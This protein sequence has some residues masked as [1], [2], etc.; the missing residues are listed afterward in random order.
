MNKTSKVLLS[1][2]IPLLFCSIAFA[3]NPAPF[4]DITKPVNNFTTSQNTLSVT[5]VFGPYRCKH[6]HEMLD[7]IEL[8]ILMIDSKKVAT[9]DLPKKDKDGRKDFTVNISSYTAGS[10]ILKAFAFKD[11]KGKHQ[12]AQSDPV[13]FIIQRG[14]TPPVPPVTTAASG[15]IVG[16]VLDSDMQVP[17]ISAS[18]TLR[19]VTGTV[20]TDNQGKYQFPSPAAGKYVIEFRKQGYTLSQRPVTVVSTR[21]TAVESVYM[22]QAD[23]VITNI[24]TAGGTYINSAGDV[25]I[26]I[27]SNA[28]SGSTASIN[29]QGTVFNHSSQLPGPL[30]TTSFFT[31]CLDLQPD[32]VHFIKPV[33]VK[34]ANTLNFLIGSQIPIGIYNTTTQRWDDTGWKGTVTADGKWIEFQTTHFSSPDCNNGPF[35]PVAQVTARSPHKIRDNTT[36]N[37]NQALKCSKVPGTSTVWMRTGELSQEH[38]LPSFK[39]LNRDF[40]LTLSYTSTTADPRAKIGFDLSADEDSYVLPKVTR[41]DLMLAGKMVR[42]YFQPAYGQTSYNYMFDC[43]DVNGKELSTGSYAYDLYATY[44]YD[45]LTYGNTDKFA[46]PVTSD[47]QV[48]L[49]E[50]CPL[51]T[52]SKSRFIVNNQQG[53]V[54]GAGWNLKGLQRIY[55]DPDGALLLT[56]GDS[57]A[58]VFEKQA[59]PNPENFAIATVFSR[60]FANVSDGDGAFAQ[61]I[62]DLSDPTHGFYEVEPTMVFADFNN[63]GN[64]DMAYTYPKNWVANY[65]IYVFFGNGD[66]TFKDPI[67][68]NIGMQTVKLYTADVN[69]DSF[70]DLIVQT[71]TTVEVLLGKGDGTFS[72]SVFSLASS[73]ASLPKLALLDDLNGDHKVDFVFRG[74]GDPLVYLGNGNGTFSAA[75]MGPESGYHTYGLVTADFTGDGKKDITGIASADSV[76]SAVIIYPGNGDGSYQTPQTAISLGNYAVNQLVVADFNQDSMV[77]IAGCI[78]SGNMQMT[79][80]ICLG[81]GD[82]TFQS[83]TTFSPIPGDQYPGDMQYMAV[84]DYNHDSIPDLLVSTFDQGSLNRAIV[85][86]GNGDGTFQPP[87]INFAQARVVAFSP[88]TSSD[89]TGLYPKDA[90]TCKEGE[91]SYILKNTD[92]SYSRYLKDGTKINFNTL[93]VETQEIDKNG[94]TTAFSYAD[95]NADGKA[96]ELTSITLPT[97]QAYNFTY[98]NGKVASISDPA[99]KVTRLNIN[100]T[101][102][103]TQIT[104]ADNTQRIFAYDAKHLMTTKTDESNHITQY[105]YDQYGTIN[106]VYS[107]ERSVT[108]VDQSG[109]VTTARKQET[110]LYKAS[111]VIGLINDLSEEIDNPSEVVRPENITEIYTDGKNANWITKTNKFGGRKQYVDPLGNTTNYDRDLN[112]NLSKLTRPNGSTVEMRYDGKGN[113]IQILENTNS[114]LTKI[115]YEKNFNQPYTITDPKGNATLIDYDAKGNPIKITDSLGNISQM[116]YNAKGQVTKVISAFNTAIQNEVN[117]TYDPVTFNLR[118]ITDQLGRHS[119]F[120]YDSAGNISM[121]TDANGHATNFSYDQMNRVKTATDAN[122]KVTTYGYDTLGN[123]TTVMDANNHTTTFTYDEQNQLTKTTNPLNEQKLYSYDVNRNLSMVVTPNGAQIKIY[124]DPANLVEKKILPEQT[125]SYTYDSQYNLARATNADSDLSFTYDP[126]SRLTLAQTAGTSINYAYDI[127]SNLTSMTDPAGAITSYIYDNLNRLTDIQQAGQSISHYNYDALSRRTEKQFA[128]G[129]QQFA[130]N[131]SYDLASQLLSITNLPTSITDTYTYDKVGNRLSLADNNGFHNYVYDNVYRLSSSSNP[132]ENY[133]YDPVGNR[134]PLSQTYDSGNRLL[135][136]GTY[137]YT[138]DH[139]GN[140]TKK[141]KK[142]GSDTTTYSYNSEDQLIGVVTPTQ[143]ISYKYDALGRRIEKNVAGTISKY[144]YDGEDI[145][146]ELD[147]NNQVVA[148]YTHGPG[149]DEPILLE[150]NGQKYYYIADGLGSI[151]AIVDSNGNIAQIYRYD[152]F[153]NI[154]NTT[155]SLNQPYT[156]TGREYDSET[157]LYY[158]RARYYDANTGRFLQEDPIGLAGGM[159]LYLYVN[160]NPINYVDPLGLLEVFYW[161]PIGGGEGSSGGWYGHVSIRLD[162]GTYISYWPSNPLNSNKI[163]IDHTPPFAPNYDRD[164]KGEGGREPEKIHITGLDE[165]KIKEWWESGYHGDFSAFNNC[166][167]IVSMALRQGGARI[168]Y[169]IVYEPRQVKRDVNNFLK[170]RRILDWRH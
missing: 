30:P 102:D 86:P 115:T 128:V 95:Q 160:S 118:D 26:T 164:K 146:E 97:S 136:D 103:L 132:N 58:M 24:T 112:S 10:H 43:K 108:E 42:K 34:F 99:G 150:K 120:S 66:G 110:R 4:V 9:Y 50:L 140:M 155:G 133:S 169:H 20:L 14:P 6:K 123:L 31:Y 49:R 67:V 36:L 142:V 89:K 53:S 91:F 41:I 40:S 56:T 52:P 126:L 28:L 35:I 167:A 122:N 19:G 121:A 134:N 8:I 109:N 44:L 79:P 138:Y 111:D 11:D 45:K 72:P 5:V 98:A 23:P 75:P 113:L 54:F 13:T 114:A 141:V 38:S 21:Y 90:Y 71:Y 165:C 32:G 168:P 61:T 94:N 153:G 12:I 37:N 18:I 59:P 158:F 64:I 157:G 147:G 81:N 62:Y 170:E 47:S 149:I 29:V 46:G 48:P 16:Q 129:S 83:V 96:D 166:S 70:Q 15:F 161:E 77:D 163:L 82:G 130:A 154:L 162:D 135:D 124:N 107:P 22:K 73:Q 131:Y 92:G 152:S 116:Q 69:N 17:L 63:D 156:Y 125:Y 88:Y 127:S 2:V 3:C 78:R 137:T 68:E 87:L 7:K 119:T 139:D 159:N 101:G 74:F 51:T 145:I 100:A 65:N 106:K 80:F 27:P 39:A 144:I 76:N 93:G 104:N 148:T 105:F 60:I 33:T 1:V 25:Q 117:F 143:T 85:L 57:T 151:T 84:S 55:P